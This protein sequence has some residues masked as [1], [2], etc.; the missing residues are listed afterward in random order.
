MKRENRWCVLCP[1]GKTKLE[2]ERVKIFETLEKAQ[3]YAYDGRR[4]RRSYIVRSLPCVQ[5]N[6]YKPFILDFQ[7]P[8]VKNFLN[9]IR[10]QT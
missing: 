5:W 10:N 9:K 4:Q 8:Y 6:E 2:R 1:N 3:H 7:D